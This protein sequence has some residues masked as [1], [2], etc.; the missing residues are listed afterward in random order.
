MVPT[1]LTL[2]PNPANISPRTE[3]PIHLFLFRASVLVGGVSLQDWPGLGLQS[4]HLAVRPPANVA[5]VAPLAS[6]LQ[7]EA[8][9][10]FSFLVAGKGLSDLI[11]CFDH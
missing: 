11:R 10:L 2:H 8:A 3:I 1:W 5:Q 9:Q 4:G 6:S 7:N